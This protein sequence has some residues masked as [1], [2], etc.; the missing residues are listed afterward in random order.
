MLK[1]TASSTFDISTTKSQETVAVHSSCGEYASPEVLGLWRADREQSS[2]P[3][4]SLPGALEEWVNE[5]VEGSDK[6]YLA[7][8]KGFE[9]E[10]SDEG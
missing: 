1:R 3:R 6:G 4:P 5:P 7:T 9:K 2:F 10:K 8:K